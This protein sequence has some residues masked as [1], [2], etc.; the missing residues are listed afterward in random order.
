MRTTGGLLELR[1]KA[2]ELSDTDVAQGIVPAPG[3]YLQVTVKDT[4]SGIAPEVQ[5]R[6]FD[7]F[8][9]TKS[10]GEGTGMGLALVHAI[11][12]S[13]GGAITVD[14]TVGEGTTFSLYLPHMRESPRPPRRVAPDVS[15]W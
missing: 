2:L 11:I 4:G 5:A 13:H 15:S 8:F 14:T 3:S 12:T 10:V 7:P 1:V 9:T 6:M